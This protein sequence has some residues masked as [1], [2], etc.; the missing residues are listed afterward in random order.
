MEPAKIPDSGRENKQ[1]LLSLQRT[2]SQKQLSPFTNA[3]VTTEEATNKSQQSLLSAQ[4]ERSTSHQFLKADPSQKFASSNSQSP[5]FSSRIT[6]FDEK[7]KEKEINK[8]TSGGEGS[9]TEITQNTHKTYF[10]QTFYTDGALSNIDGVK[11][12]RV[13]KRVK[14]KNFHLIKSEKNIL[15][16]IFL[17]NIFIGWKLEC[18]FYCEFFFLFLLK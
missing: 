10:V 12:W 18:E 3:K 7:D 17:G 5:H 11:N 8:S 16:K 14:S 9:T 13:S 4:R 6:N 2:N 15:K 1:S